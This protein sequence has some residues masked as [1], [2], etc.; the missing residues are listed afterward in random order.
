MWCYCMTE[1][2]KAS[3]LY[4]SS[5]PEVCGNLDDDVAEIL[6]MV[7]AEDEEVLD[8]REVVILRDVDND[9][10]EE[11]VEVIG[12][13]SKEEADEMGGTIV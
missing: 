12:R 5:T 13:M 8:E 1:R 2:R 7:T 9:V 11:V 3:I 6:D 4:G 10:A